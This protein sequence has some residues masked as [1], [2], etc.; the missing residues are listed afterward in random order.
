[1]APDLEKREKQEI[2]TTAAEKMN[3]SGPAF[4]PDVNIY[5]SQN[6][7]VF[8][9]ELPGVAKGDVNIEVDENNTL[10]IKA[11]NSFTEP[12]NILLKQYNVGNYYR[13]FQI[14][15]EYDKDSISAK[16]EN[17]LLEISVPK[18]EE[19][20]PRRIEIKA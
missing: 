12:E 18:K 11:K 7:V 3:Q 19:A 10:I 17:G 9:I 8:S 2:T 6:E 1:M 4:S 13:A 14:S 15:D 16:L 20:K 5:A